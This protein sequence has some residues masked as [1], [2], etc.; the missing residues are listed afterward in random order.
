MWSRVHDE[1][2]GVE[3]NVWLRRPGRCLAKENLGTD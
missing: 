3:E 1:V 2:Y